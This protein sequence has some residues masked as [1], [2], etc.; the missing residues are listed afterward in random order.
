MGPWI[1][2]FLVVKVLKARGIEINKMQ[3]INGLNRGTRDY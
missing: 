2:V 1:R 3:K